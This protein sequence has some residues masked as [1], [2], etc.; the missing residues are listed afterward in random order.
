MNDL[1]T[2]YNERLIPLGVIPFEKLT[3]IK[4]VAL[5]ASISFAYWKSGNSILK[6]DEIII[7]H[8]NLRK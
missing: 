4:L 6:F 8:L 2:Y 3:K 1:Q 7:D 5:K